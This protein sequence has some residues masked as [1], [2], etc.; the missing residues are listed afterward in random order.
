MKGSLTPRVP[1]AAAFFKPKG[2]L[3]DLPP[4]EQAFHVPLNY[5]RRALGREKTREAKAARV[6]YNNC[7]RTGALA[8]DAIPQTGVY[9]NLTSPHPRAKYATGRSSERGLCC[10]KHSP[11]PTP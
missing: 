4:P 6:P 7:R 3:L 9:A 1:P 8:I 10:F 5:T 11:L 2:G